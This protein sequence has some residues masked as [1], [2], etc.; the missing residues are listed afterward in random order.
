[1]LVFP[2][3]ILSY[4]RVLS[5]HVALSPFI[6]SDVGLD[7]ERCKGAKLVCKLI[8]WMIV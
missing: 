4:V 8:W 5:V 3:L 1:M 7:E 2:V 6:T